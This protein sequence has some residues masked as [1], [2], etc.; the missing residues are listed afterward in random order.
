MLDERIPVVAH[1]GHRY[2]VEVHDEPAAKATVLV[3]PAMGVT[4]AKTDLYFGR[5]KAPVE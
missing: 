3:L 2:A 1:D 4:R 5:E